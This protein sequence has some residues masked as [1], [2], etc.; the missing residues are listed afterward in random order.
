[1]TISRKLIGVGLILILPFLLVAGS[2][3]CYLVS[4]TYQSA[5]ILE[6]SQ[7]Y[8]EEAVREPVEASAAENA[9]RKVAL[10][11][12]PTASI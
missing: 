4:K 8:S 5:V 2:L 10:S 9:F 1:M 3:Y 12:G 6:H 11:Y 7:P